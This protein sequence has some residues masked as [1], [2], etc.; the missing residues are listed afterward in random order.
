MCSSNSTYEQP[1]NSIE[2]ITETLKL[3][4]FSF[5]RCACAPPAAH[6]GFFRFP[7]SHGGVF[8]PTKE[9]IHH[10]K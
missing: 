9:V 3:Y 2:I 7:N 1:L 5:V 8:R 4:I 6:A 10:D